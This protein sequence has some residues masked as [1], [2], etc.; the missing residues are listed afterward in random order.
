MWMWTIHANA[1]VLAHGIKHSQLHAFVKVPQTHE[2]SYIAP[3]TYLSDLHLNHGGVKWKWSVHFL[4]P[5]HGDSLKTIRLVSGWT[6]LSVTGHLRW[7]QPCGRRLSLV[8]SENQNL[9][10]KHIQLKSIYSKS[11]HFQRGLSSIVYLP[12]RVLPFK[13][14]LSPIKLYWN[15]ISLEMTIHTYI[16]SDFWNAGEED[17]HQKTFRLVFGWIFNSKKQKRQNVKKKRMKERKEK[18]KSL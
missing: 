9:L 14:S 7:L 17:L 15:I 8:W 16:Y 12:C 5:S 13:Q 18:E 6:H 4:K 3:I 1:L 10:E 11:K 2:T